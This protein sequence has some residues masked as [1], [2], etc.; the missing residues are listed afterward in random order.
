[1]FLT[2]HSVPFAGLL[3]VAAVGPVLHQLDG[4]VEAQ[5]LGD[6][7]YDVHAVPLVP[8]QNP[9]IFHTCT[10]EVG[11]QTSFK[12]PQIANQHFLG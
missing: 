12:S 5:D 4:V 7:V 10:A 8:D 6:L 1:M 2:Y 9:H 11:K 3:V